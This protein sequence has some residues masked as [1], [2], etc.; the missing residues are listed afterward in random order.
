[1]LHSDTMP[2]AGALATLPTNAVAAVEAEHAVLV[3]LLATL[4]PETWAAPSGCPGW[5]V[6]DLVAHLGTLFWRMADPSRLP[7]TSGLPTE[8]AQ[9]HDVASRATWTPERIVTDYVEAATRV[10]PVLERLRD[11]DDPVP[12][13]DLGTFP[14]SM[15]ACGYAFDHYTHIRAD[16]LAPRGPLDVPAPPSDELRMGPTVVWIMAALPQ[17][18]AAALTGLAGPVELLLTGPGGGLFVL[19][20]SGAILSGNDARVDTVASISCSTTDLVWWSTRRASWSD[21]DVHTAGDPAT[22]ALLRDQVHVF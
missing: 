22:L 18:C 7:D 13:G 15:L 6:K 4:A 9:D 14:A 3:D 5:T 8:R 11:V 2:S 12:L 21:L 10:L 19:L 20:P 16:L 1:M 17:Q